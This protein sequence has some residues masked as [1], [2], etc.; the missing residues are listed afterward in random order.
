MKLLKNKLLVLALVLSSL[1]LLISSV[2]L[3]YIFTDTDEVQ[4]T[5]T[6]GEVACEVQETFNKGDTVKTDVSVK[7][8]GNV[9]AYIRAAV[10]ITWVKTDENG[11]VTSSKTPILDTDYSITYKANTDWQRGAD[12]LWYYKSAVQPQT[13]TDVL[14]S[15]C[16]PI[17]EN[18]AP[19]GY[20]LSVEI[21]TMAV[22]SSPV[23][24]VTAAFGGGVTG[25]DENGKLIL[26]AG[27]AE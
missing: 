8:T 12:G 4:N 27:G 19:E 21:V 18:T 10:I 23:E 22:Q 3:A 7:N 15:E 26:K 2:T 11:T 5:F 13:D 20:T 6:P 1:V 14:I 16:K 25:I 17:D 9:T 24:A